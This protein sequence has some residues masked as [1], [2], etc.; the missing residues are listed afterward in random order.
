MPNQSLYTKLMSLADKYFG[1]NAIVVDAAIENHLGINPEKITAQELKA[2][3]V[4]LASIHAV[5]NNDT[6]QTDKL[7][8]DLMQLCGGISRRSS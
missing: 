3:S 4:W 2:M 1:E 5:L 8:D 7:T 6:K